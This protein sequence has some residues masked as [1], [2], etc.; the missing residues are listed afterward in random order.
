L[1]AFGVRMKSIITKNKVK[2]QLK[3]TIAAT[4]ESNSTTAEMIP[5]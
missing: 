3:D 2:G 1:F 5:T 4:M